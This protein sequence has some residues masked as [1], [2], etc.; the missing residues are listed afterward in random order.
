MKI[1]KLKDMIGGWFI[2]DFVPSAV[3]TKDF[4]VGV[5]LHKKGE[6]WP[7]HYHKI[8]VEINC[9]LSGRMTLQGEELNSGAIFILEPY[10][11]ADPCFLEDCRVLVVKVPSAIGDKYEV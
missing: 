8:A 6:K 4:E 11:I 7:V 3:R 2:G 5:L 10:E 1:Y 9:L